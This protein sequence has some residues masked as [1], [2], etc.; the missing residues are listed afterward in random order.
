MICYIKL[1][2]IPA[3]LILVSCGDTSNPLSSGFGSGKDRL[4]SDQEL[5]T[6]ADPKAPS[7][8]Q[9]WITWIEGNHFPVRS[10]TSKYYHDLQF[11]KP[12]LADKRLVQV[13]EN[14]HGVA[15]YN[16]VKTRL[17]K[18]LHEEMGFNVLA[19]E[20]GLFECFNGNENRAELTPLEL[21]TRSINGMWQTT[22]VLELFE[23]IQSTTD[24]ENPLIL[25]G[26]DIL[27]PIASDISGRPEFFRRVLAAVDSNY[28]G[29][30]YD[31]DVHF[32]NQREAHDQF[33]AYVA[34][35][36]DELLKQYRGIVSFIDDH[37]VDLANA[38]SENPGYPLFA[39]QMAHSTTRYI[40]RAYYTYAG[41][42][43]GSAAVRDLGMAENAEFLLTQVYPDKKIISW[44]H[45]F[46]V[47]HDSE[48]IAD[49]SYE[50]VESMGTHLIKNFRDDMYTIGLYMYRGQAAFF[51]MSIYDINAA[52]SGS[53]ESIMYHARKKY[54]FVDMLSQK[55]NSGNS[56]MFTA[57][58]AKYWGTEPE[59]IIPRNQYDAILF[60]GTVT[61]VEYLPYMQ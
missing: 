19:F 31:F 1:L 45:N 10:L 61:P 52:T 50:V 27:M 26:Y 28:A 30:I 37:E 44:A 3:L 49:A 6:E 54:C 32:L 55:K 29:E 25:A 24:T 7:E 42:T 13:G 58:T 14:S 20:S 17:V 35:H 9:S 18:F 21:L 23:Y 48:Q 59:T 16:L 5:H 43:M 33:N 11:L 47:C 57:I 2:L 8:N 34:N 4:L 51:H 12:I 15:E 36:R 53:V 60:I 38:F 41:I 22:E 39:R 56:W 40:D 46:H